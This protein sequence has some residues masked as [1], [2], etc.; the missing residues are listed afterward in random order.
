MTD[1]RNGLLTGVLVRRTLTAV[2]L[3]DVVLLLLTGVHEELKADQPLVKPLVLFSLVQEATVGAWWSSVV[4]AAAGTGFVLLA[5]TR[6]W[7]QQRVPRV[8]V[9][10]AGGL[11]LLGLSVDEVASVHERMLIADTAGANRAFEGA[12]PWVVPALPLLALVACGIRH[13]SGRAVRPATWLNWSGTLCLSTILLQEE[14]EFS[15]D[16]DAARPTWLTL[17]EEGTELLGS[18]LLLAGALVLLRALPAEALAQLARGA[19]RQ[20]LGLTA[21]GATLLVLGAVTADLLVDRST[22]EDQLGLPQYWTGSVATGALAASVLGWAHRSASRSRAADAL[23]L[24]A[25][26]LAVLHGMDG[27]TWA[28]RLTGTDLPA[29][30]AMGLLLLLPALL[31]ARHALVPAL[32]TVLAAALTVTGQGAASAIE[33]VVSCLSAVA[34]TWATSTQEEQRVVESPGP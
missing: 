18:L 22:A 19:R 30:L 34:W 9:P 4:L 11:L 8:A 21:L 2:A 5:V 20:R 27:F 15:L 14:L 12:G 10:A 24:A 32:S 25:V 23:A 6:C 29:R 26:L 31:L 33:V 17:L 28:E 3:A 1:V 16:F 7:G 13:L